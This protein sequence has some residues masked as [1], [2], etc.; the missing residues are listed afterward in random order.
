MS[1]GQSGKDAASDEKRPSF[2]L[3]PA[4]QGAAKPSRA[5]RKAG[6]PEADPPRTLDGRYMVVR[7][8]LWRLSDPGLAPDRRKALVDELMAARS[9]VGQTSDDSQRRAA[10]ARVDAAK[11]GLGERGPVWWRDG[12]PDLNR[13]LARNTLYADWW[14]TFLSSRAGGSDPT[15]ASAL[16]ATIC[17]LSFSAPRNTRRNQKTDKSQKTDPSHEIAPLAHST[18]D[19]GPFP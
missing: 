1:A 12:A 8:R 14:A 9:A 19:R 10:R 15:G 7:G 11:C 4:V 3:V 16:N 13:R 17:N 5:V 2:T 6:K 18:A